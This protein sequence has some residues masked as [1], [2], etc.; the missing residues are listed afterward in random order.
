M[1]LLKELENLFEKSLFCEIIEKVDELMNSNESQEIFNHSKE[2]Y[3]SVL[4]FYAMAHYKLNHFTTA[5]SFFSKSYDITKKIDCLIW[6]CEAYY[7]QRNFQQV[8]S[9]GVDVLKRTDSK[10]KSIIEKSIDSIVLS[11]FNNFALLKDFC[12]EL[13]KIS[14][15]CFRYIFACLEYLFENE[16]FDVMFDIAFKYLNICK[17]NIESIENVLNLLFAVMD[18]VE[19]MNLKYS[20]DLFDIVK[21]FHEDFIIPKCFAKICILNFESTEGLQVI[22]PYISDHPEDYD[23]III[24]AELL[25]MEENSEE[26]FELLLSIESNNLENFK[27][28]SL[29][30]G[31][32]DELFYDTETERKIELYS[33]LIELDDEYSEAYACRGWEKYKLGDIDEAI[34]DLKRSIIIDPDNEEAKCNLEYIVNRKSN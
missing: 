16:E 10:R 34:S 23:A 9:I 25:I 4:Y 18:T 30:V 24:K 12:F 13:M 5:I 7:D 6:K 21:E 2:E 27:Y 29:L 15:F 26:A 22:E 1:N 28:Y 3:G 33:K 11:E 19:E 17:Q 31:L 14:K 8:I 32:Y 20:E